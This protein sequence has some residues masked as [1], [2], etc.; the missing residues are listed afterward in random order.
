MVLIITDYVFGK[1]KMRTEQIKFNTTKE[2][3]KRIKIYCK[4]H[5]LT[6]ADFI[7]KAISK[8]LA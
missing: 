8:I 5:K 7:R 2:G 1:K 4:K 3:K 6:I